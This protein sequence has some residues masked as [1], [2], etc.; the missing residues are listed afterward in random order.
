M[1]RVLI[2]EDDFR[3]A[4][5]HESL[6]S[7]FS[8]F[9]CVGKA[10]NVQAM[11]SQIREQTIDLILLDLY[12]PDGL[13]VEQILDVKSAAPNVD[14]IVIT[15]SDERDHVQKAIRYGVYDYI[16]KSHSFERLEKSL[17]NYITYFNVMNRLAPFDQE[18]I[19]QLLERSLK[20][21][22]S[23][24]S[25]LP[26]GID[27]M[28]LHHVQQLLKSMVEGITA[29]EMGEKLGASRTT[30]RRYLEYLIQLE[31]AVA[32]PV[33]GVV[34]RPERKYFLK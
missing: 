14:I 19:D 32:M 23:D 1:I 28:T 5:V 34:G 4:N 25:D 13:G 26:K 27:G 15:A 24:F 11:M 12:L 33:Y 6:V 17:A 31:R 18:H 29:E 21:E 3:V 2:C 7:Q 22:S 8:S 10:S 9:E 30:A 16:I 20:P